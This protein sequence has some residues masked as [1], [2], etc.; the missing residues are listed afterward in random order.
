MPKSRFDREFFGG[1]ALFLSAIIALIFYNS[2]YGDAYRSFFNEPFTLTVGTF[3]LVKTYGHCIND[4]LM[5][6]FF[7]AIGLELKR[8]L[9]DGHL[10]SYESV[11]LP[12]VA[13]LGG[14]L[15]PLVIY[16]SFNFTHSEALPGWAIPTATDIAFMLGVLA[17]LGRGV[18]PALKVFL[19]T[20]AVFDDLVA[21][22]IIAVF[23]SNEL[24]INYLLLAAS[25]LASLI[26]LNHLGVR[27]IVPYVLLGLVMW[28]FVLKSGIHATLA[29]VILGL[30]IP[31]KKKEGQLIS[32]S[33]KMEKA[34]SPWVSFFVLPLFALANAGVPLNN[35][36]FTE[37]SGITLGVALGLFFG[38]QIGVFSFAWLIIKLKVSRL[39]QGCNWTKM[40]AGA[41]L[42]GIGFTMSLFI[43]SLAFSDGHLIQQANLGI[44]LGTFCSMIYGYFIMRRAIRGRD[45]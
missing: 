39:P 45:A 34:L 21:I 33:V 24:S 43:A 38:K 12:A 44:L 15:I 29:G 35:I 5:A 25:V 16:T 2:P 36:N 10:S 18:P 28:F 9:I 31:Y 19:L 20:L 30:V 41:A 42:C 22:T 11:V 4:G 26:V 37:L 8:E 3:T 6:I 1:L 14:I 17:V 40:Y 23:Y 7:L 13:A 27:K 32:T